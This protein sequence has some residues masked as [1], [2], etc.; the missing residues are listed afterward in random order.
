MKAEWLDALADSLTGQPGLELLE[1]RRWYTRQGGMPVG[2]YAALSDE[3]KE[4]FDHGEAM[5]ARTPRGQ[6]LIRVW[7]GVDVDLI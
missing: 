4:V 3:D 1:S 7:H 5:I 2:A 6:L